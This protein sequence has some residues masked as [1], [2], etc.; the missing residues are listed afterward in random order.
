MFQKE[1]TPSTDQSVDMQ[2]VRERSNNLTPSFISLMMTSL[3]CSKRVS[4][5]SVQLNLVAVL[6]RC[7]NG[8]ILLAIVNAYAPW[9]TIPNQARALEMS[10]AVG[11]CWMEFRNFVLGL[12]FVNATVMPAN[13]TVSSANWN[14]FGFNV[15]P[16]QVHRSNQRHVWKMPPQCWLLTCM[17][18]PR[19]S[20]CL[21][22]CDDG[23]KTLVIAIS[24]GEESLWGN[25]I[26]VSPPPPP[27]DVIKVVNCLSSG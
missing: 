21:E 11:K 14:F 18:R 10:V 1:F 17:C 5:S 15:I 2:V 13:S 7:L 27:Q 24:T 26:S 6:K 20:I 23:I 12:M 22:V 4:S 25:F 19:I 8:F 3:D 16:L 9:L